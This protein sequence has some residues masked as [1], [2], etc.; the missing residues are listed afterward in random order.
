MLSRCK[1]NDLGC[2]LQQQQQQCL[3]LRPARHWLKPLPK[4]GWA[5]L[6]PG[7]GA[8][9]KGQGETGSSSISQHRSCALLPA[10]RETAAGFWAEQRYN[11]TPGCF[12]QLTGSVVILTHRSTHMLSTLLT[13]RKHPFLDDWLHQALL[14]Y[15][16]H[17]QPTLSLVMHKWSSCLLPRPELTLASLCLSVIRSQTIT[18]ALSLKEHKRYICKGSFLGDGSFPKPEAAEMQI[19]WCWGPPESFTSLLDD[20]LLNLGL[21]LY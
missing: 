13:Y 14:W 9:G 19:G 3:A 6:Q 2:L 18:T 17:L 20:R 10:S 21:Q 1:A 11:F 8:E 7:Q 5:S 16:G 4:P 15:S 12:F